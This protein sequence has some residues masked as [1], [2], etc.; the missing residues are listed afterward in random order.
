NVS[1]V[2]SGAV[3]NNPGNSNLK[4]EKGSELEVG[5]DASFL[6]DRVSLELTHFD[7]R[8]KD[9]I[10]AQPLPPSLG[11]LTNPQV[12]IGGVQNTGFEVSVSATPIRSRNLNWDV[13]V[14]GATLHN[15]L[16]DLGGVAAFGTLNRFTKGYQLGSFVSKRI[17]SINEAT[18][19]VTVG[20]TLE[21]A[22][23][24]F[25]TFEGT[26]S[27][28]VTLFKQLRLS[29]QLDTKRDF[30][31]YNNTEFFR[32]TQVVTSNQ[33]LD[34]LQMTRLQ[35]LRKYGNPA[36]GQPAFVQQ[37]GAA[38]TVA[39]A[40]DGFLQPGDFTRIRE[41]SATWNIPH[42]YLGMLGKVQTASVAFAVQN[43]KLWKNKAFTGADPE[44]ISSGN[45]STGAG[46]FTR[47]DFLTQAAPRTTVFRLNLTF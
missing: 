30:L 10:L 40:R 4:P 41:V 5:I 37:N 14:G 46:Q 16:T 36:A 44:V 45:G 42:R 34:T 2:E 1:V 6:N 20:D 26:F 8:T 39:E 23:N 11:F 9:L 18:G 38:T 25:P 29:G 35:R 13:I 7:K 27:T 12:N 43:V 28:T 21:V 22:G 47:D 15:E 31:V 33:R 19:V 24:I 32:E 17:K 3:P